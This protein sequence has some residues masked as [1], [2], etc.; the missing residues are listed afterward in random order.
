M[1]LVRLLRHGD[2]GALVVFFAISRLESPATTQDASINLNTAGKM[3][4]GVYKY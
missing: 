4:K 1:P 2:I 3:T